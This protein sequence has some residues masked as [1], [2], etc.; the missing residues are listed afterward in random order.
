MLVTASHV[1]GALYPNRAAEI[2]AI[3]TKLPMVAV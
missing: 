1:G 3:A 2:I